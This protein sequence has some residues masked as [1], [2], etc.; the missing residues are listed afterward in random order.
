VTQ[1][2]APRIATSSAL[3]QPS[4]LATQSAIDGFSATIK[5]TGT[6]TMKSSVAVELPFSKRQ[7]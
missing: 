4:A 6:A 5:T 7:E 2:D 3:G 1:G